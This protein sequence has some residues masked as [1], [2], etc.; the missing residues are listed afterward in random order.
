MKL[1]LDGRLLRA[2]RTAEKLESRQ[3]EGI[4]RTI[5]DDH[6]T[7]AKSYIRSSEIASDLIKEIKEECDDL[8]GFL[9]ATQVRLINFLQFSADIPTDS[10]RNQSK[11]RG[12]N[13]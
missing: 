12:H 10:G 7:A 13:R 1:I 4:I 9:E 6:I 11:V 3:F 8:A 5:C 2:A